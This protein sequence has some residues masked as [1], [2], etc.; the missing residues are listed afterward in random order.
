MIER[1]VKELVLGTK[2]ISEGD[3]DHF[4]SVTTSDEMGHLATSFNQMT[5]DLQKA[6]E[7]FEEKTRDHPY[8]SPI[9]ENVPPP[10]YPNPVRGVE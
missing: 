6:R 2:R 3:L 10:Q 5:S 8:V 4:I 9:P 7:E 1:P